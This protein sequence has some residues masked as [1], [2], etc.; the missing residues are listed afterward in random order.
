MKS[1]FPPNNRKNLMNSRSYEYFQ[2]LFANTERLKRS[3]IVYMQNLLNQDIERKIN[4]DKL[5]IV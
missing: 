4:Q 3:P 1:L 2:V 5:W